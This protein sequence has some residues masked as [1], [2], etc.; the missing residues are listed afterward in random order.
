MQEL[1]TALSIE[2]AVAVPPVTC[3]LKL[4]AVPATTVL[5]DALRV[6]VKGTVTVVVRGAA[7][8]PGPDALIVNVVVDF[9]GTI[10]DPEVGSEPVYRFE[11]PGA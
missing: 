7:A 11:A 4:T 10:E 1:H 3:Q 6:R 2:S 9:T 5:G 8:P